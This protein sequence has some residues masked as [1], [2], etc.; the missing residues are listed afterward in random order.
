MSKT[1]KRTFQGIFQSIRSV[2]ISISSYQPELCEFFFAC[3]HAH[4]HQNR[5]NAFSANRKYKV[6]E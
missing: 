4:G 6:S 1:Y 5:Y 2:S 3:F